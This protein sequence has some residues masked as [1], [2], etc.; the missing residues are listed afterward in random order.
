MMKKKISRRNFIQAAGLGVAG[1]QT[2]FFINKANAGMGGGGMGGG[3][4]GGG[5]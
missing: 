1:L 3:G 5:G 2:G 4:C